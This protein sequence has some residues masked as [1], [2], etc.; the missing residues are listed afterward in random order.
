[1]P[2]EIS[3]IEDVASEV[4]TI[5]ET[6][7]QINDRTSD[8]KIKAHLDASL[9]KRLGDKSLEDLV[10]E[11]VAEI[12]TKRIGQN[13][14]ANYPNPGGSAGGVPAIT[15]F[16]RA[17]KYDH[18]DMTKLFTMYQLMKAS[19]GVQSLKRVS[20]K[21][22]SEGPSDDLF[23]ALCVR[24]IADADRSTVLESQKILANSIHDGMPRHRRNVIAEKIASLQQSHP[25]AV[26]ALTAAAAAG[27]P[28][29]ANEI[30]NT[31]L[32]NYGDQWTGDAWSA[33]MWEQVETM[34]PIAMKMNEI[35]VPRGYESL[36]IPV[37][38]GRPEFYNVEQA[39]DQLSSANP[40]LTAPTVQTS[41]YRTAQA[42]ATLHKIGC[43]VTFA[44]EL[45][46]DVLLDFMNFLVKAII[47]EWGHVL[48][49]AILDGDTV[50]GNTNINNIRS[51]GAISGSDLVNT[52]WNGLRKYALSTSGK[53]YDAGAYTG[54]IP[55]LVLKIIALYGEAGAQGLQRD[56]VCLVA[57]TPFEL[58][59]NADSQI[60]D[61]EKRFYTVENSRVTGIQGYEYIHSPAFFRESANRLANT[62]GNIS[63]TASAN[64]RTGL[65]SFRPDQWYLVKKRELEMTVEYNARA[66]AY[67]LTMLTRTG[68]VHQT[69]SPSCSTIAYDVTP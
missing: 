16:A 14:P 19:E 51:S 44:K 43:A 1:M 55:D 39:A 38:A 32:T 30:Q 61:M 47:E 59:V 8:E 52:N 54:T 21:G 50:T 3:N 29:K 45:T 27:M 18:L 49:N 53:S 60:K 4:K 66:D 12:V 10:D 46:E 35:W 68:L 6:V 2:Q 62:A 25:I 24:T 17:A 58:N 42:N 48:D 36:T 9:E 20:G 23:Y 63:T 37:E 5:G 41:R 40:G 56:K 64:T 22:P 31:E 11:K 26:R 69:S 28:L 65:M 15:Q 33:M 67:E 7:G 13:S 34:A 57:P